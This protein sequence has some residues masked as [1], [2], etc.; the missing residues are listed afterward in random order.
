LIA[1]VKITSYNLHCSAPF[2]RALVV[3]ATKSTRKEEPTTSSNQP[4][5]G[6]HLKSGLP[7]TQSLSATVAIQNSLLDYQEQNCD[8]DGEC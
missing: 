1:R 6:Q 4:R 3:S 2:F 5:R 8:Q 7:G